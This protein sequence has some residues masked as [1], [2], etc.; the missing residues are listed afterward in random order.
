MQIDRPPALTAGLKAQ[1]GIFHLLPLG[2]RVQQKI[3]ALLDKHMQSI[4][5]PKA[6]CIRLE[7]LLTTLHLTGASRLSLSTVTSEELWQKS[8]RLQG[9]SSEVGLLRLHLRGVLTLPS[10]SGSPTA[11]R[12]HSC[13]RQPTRKKSQP[14]YQ[15]P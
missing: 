2:L 11:G 13:C 9:I 1:P 4:G 15:G 10:S 12:C 7:I 14:S 3:E 5:S 8:G 6:V